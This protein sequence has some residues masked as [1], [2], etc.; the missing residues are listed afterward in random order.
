MGIKSLTQTIKKF[1]PDSIKND[2]LYK[3]SGKTIAVDASL[4]IYQQLL[5]NNRIFTN[6]NGKITNH[7][8]GLFYKIM[9]YI[10]YNINLIF[11]FDGKPPENKSMTIQKR[12]QKC[13]DAQKELDIKNENFSILDAIEKLNLVKSRSEIKRLIKSDGIKVN[14]QLYKNSD[15]SLKKYLEHKEIKISV[16][17]KKVGILKVL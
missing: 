1:S 17:K 2:N 9:L 13:I 6:K 15:L 4:I 16:G 5:N 11:I 3:L 7:I 8:T 12:K 14:D 10:S